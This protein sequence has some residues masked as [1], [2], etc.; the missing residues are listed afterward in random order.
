MGV[1]V[2]RSQ[3]SASHCLDRAA[4]RGKY[5]VREVESMGPATLLCVGS[6]GDAEM[7]KPLIVS[8]YEARSTPHSL[9][10]NRNHRIP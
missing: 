6:Q 8:C 7:R 2:P 5:Y 4:S 10:G 3:S 9:V 1:S